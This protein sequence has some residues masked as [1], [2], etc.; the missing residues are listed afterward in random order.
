MVHKRETQYELLLLLGAYLI[1]NSVSTAG[2]QISF[3]NN[4]NAEVSHPVPTSS[5]C[6]TP[7]GLHGVCVNLFLCDPIVSLLKRKPLPPSIINHLRKSVCK[8]KT[9]APDVCCPQNAGNSKTSPPG[10]KRH[11]WSSF[12]GCWFSLS[13]NK[14]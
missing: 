11:Y 1:L 4:V 8:R 7:D 13:V 14:L 12:S 9:P 3:Q 2:D 5:V 10:L 6:T